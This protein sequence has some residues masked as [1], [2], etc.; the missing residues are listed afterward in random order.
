MPTAL[1]RVSA[2]RGVT[3]TSVAGSTCCFECAEGSL[4]VTTDHSGRERFVYKLRGDGG[5]ITTWVA[6]SNLPP[7]PPKSSAVPD[8]KVMKWFE[9]CCKSGCDVFRVEV[10]ANCSFAITDKPGYLYSCT[11]FLGN[12]CSHSGLFV[13][14]CACDS[15]DE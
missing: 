13:D 11:C 3:F 8:P 7:P 1:E 9:A 15:D 10:C 2:A 5:R 12:R 14:A 4:R 6:L